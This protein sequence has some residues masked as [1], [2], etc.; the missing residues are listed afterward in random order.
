MSKIEWTDK[1]WNP[2]TGCTK[3]SV[4]CDNCYAERMAY[5]LKSMGQPRYRYGFSVRTHEDVLRAPYRWKKSRRV[6]VCSMADLFHVDVSLR[7]IQSVFEAMHRNPA[8]TFQVLTKRSG[9]MLDLSK[10]LP[11]PANIWTGVSVENENFLCRARHLLR[12]PAETRFLSLEPLL[13]PLPNLDVGPFDWVIA[14][15]ESGPGAR[16]V[17]PDWV[18]EIRDK[19]IASDVPF[20]FKQWGGTNKKKTGR[21]LDGVEWSQFPVTEPDG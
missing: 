10:S 9:R 8:H 21:V 19:C 12:V 16:P 18:R 7:F 20:F 6:F 13:G 11:W 14:G 4:G 17:D 1:T 3:L 2:V 15:G 5:R